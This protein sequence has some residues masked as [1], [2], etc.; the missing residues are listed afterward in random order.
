MDIIKDAESYLEGYY[1]LK[2]S[3]INI[4]KE[5]ELLDEDIK[6]IKNL[7]YSGMSHRSEVSHSDD[8]LVNLLYKK[9][10]KESLLERTKEKVAFIDNI[11][12]KLSKEEDGKVLKAYYIDTLRKEEL[13]KAIGSSER[14][15]Y[16]MKNKALRRFAIQL[17]GIVALGV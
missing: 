17:F 13:E 14:N 16:R 11:L 6:S 1:D 3:I 2:N 4:T 5:I 12:T 10:V 15:I 7:D 9:Q 8:R